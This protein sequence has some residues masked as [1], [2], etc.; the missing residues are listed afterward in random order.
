MHNSLKFSTQL[1]ELGRK[2]LR[3][4][5]QRE[6][7]HVL[8]KLAGL[9]ELAPDVAEQTQVHLAEIYLRWNKHRKA[10]RHLQAA[11]ARD[12]RCAKYHHL[13][14]TA[15]DED[16][17]GDEDRA[18]HH[19]RRAVE[20]DPAEP[21]FHCDYGLCLIATGVSDE[22]L[23]QLQ[24][25][26]E[27]A[28]NETKYTRLLAMSLLEAGDVDKARRSVLAARFRNPREGR[29][30]RLWDDLCFKQARQHQQRIGHDGAALTRKGPTILPF[31]QK[32]AVSKPQEE[33][34]VCPTPSADGRIIRMDPPSALPRPHSPVR[35]KRRQSR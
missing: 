24:E 30:R 2:Y 12:P 4:G 33:R 1:L 31:V 18:L 34:N 5:R 13:L 19:Y 14:A 15:L 26:A 9:G 8:G 29:L 35:S 10:R 22:G 32:K 25:A 28:P 7:L 23:K 21:A 16:K 17:D 11:L 3:F 27:L 20:L 6:A